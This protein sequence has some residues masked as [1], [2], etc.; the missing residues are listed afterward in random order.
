MA[1]FVGHRV[2]EVFA[3]IPIREVEKLLKGKEYQK[4]LEMLEVF[5]QG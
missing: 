1:H 3:G 2:Q 5:R 4:S